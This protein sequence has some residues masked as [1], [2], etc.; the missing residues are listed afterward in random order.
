LDHYNDKHL[1]E[2]K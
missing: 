2:K 1:E